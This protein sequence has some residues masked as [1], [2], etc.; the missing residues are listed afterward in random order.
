MKFDFHCHT[1]NGS[2]DARVDVWEY[3][4]LLKE[5]GFGGMMVTDHNSYNG[6][7]A[8]LEYKERYGELEDFTVLRGIEYDTLDAGHILVVMPDD[9]DL[10]ILEVRGLPIHMLVKVVHR[11]GGILGPA[12]PY[13]AK[14][15]S[16]MCSKRLDRDI[17]LIHDFDFV[18]AFNTCELPGSN[19]KARALAEKYGKVCFGGSDSHRTDYIGMAYTEI[20]S[21]VNCCD[22]LIRLVKAHEIAGCGGTERAPKEQAP[23]TKMAL[24]AVWKVYNRGL[25]AA[26]YHARILGLRELGLRGVPYSL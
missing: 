15:L 9:V 1:K 10:K 12:H 17:R 3:A 6:Y 23:I 13:G 11:Y 14:F 19:E 24:G 2:L 22:D 16:A 26:K 7:R 8:W 18:E 25:A 20:D 21:P 4:K 5:K